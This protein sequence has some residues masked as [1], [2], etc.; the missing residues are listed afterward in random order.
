MPRLIRAVRDFVS[1]HDG[2]IA[3]SAALLFPLLMAAA[4]LVVDEASL[5]HQKRQLQ[6]AVDMAA[7][8]AAADPSNA[9]ALAHRTLLDHGAVD[10]AISLVELADPAAGRLRVVVGRYAPD[11]D[12]AVS[13]RFIPGANPPNAV[14]VRYEVPGTLHFARVFMDEAPRVAADALASATPRAG[15]SIGSRLAR[16]D[17]GAVNGLLGELVGA[18]LSL[19]LVDYDAIAGLDITLSG[20]LDALA[21]RVG[22]SAGTYGEVLGARV[23]LSDIA[24]ALAA[25]AGGS[26]PAALAVLTSLAGAIDDSIFVEMAKIVA[27]DGLAHLAVGTPQAGASVGVEALEMLTVAALLADGQRQAQL[28]LGL[29]VPG[30]AGISV[31]LVV[32]EPPQAAWYTFGEAGSF[33]RTAQVRL[34]IDIAVLGNGGLGVGLLNIGLPVYAELAFAEAELAALACPPGRPDLGQARLAV[35]PGVLR[36]AVGA[37]PSGSFL[38]TSRPLAISR[39]AIVNVAGIAQVT[40]RADIESARI[41]PQIVHFSYADVANRTVKTVSTSTP[42]SSLTASLIGN[43]DLRLELLGGNLLGGLLS[44]VTGTVQALLNPV[45]PALD[46]VLMTLFSILGLSVGEADVRM[47]GFDCRAAALVR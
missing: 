47:H 27:A 29:G 3:I 26:D 30:I 34:K 17:G 1:R 46:T 41:D 25:A 11:P 44:G 36:L 14:D 32:G 33:V 43:L 4:A 31:Q 15:F 16:L 22:L 7:I 19:S 13:A 38:D 37:I 5:Y 21:G 18:Q 28:G 40:A 24:V 35:R 8:H 9:L 20:F 42:L 2:N 23:R 10:P 12:L 6:A 39:G 45:A